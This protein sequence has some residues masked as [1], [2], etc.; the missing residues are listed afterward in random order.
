[1]ASSSIAALRFIRGWLQGRSLH[2]EWGREAAGKEPDLAGVRAMGSVGGPWPPGVSGVRTETRIIENGNPVR[3]RWYG[4]AERNRASRRR[5]LPGWAL[6]HGVAVQGPD[7]PGLVRFATALASAGA[8]VL[9]PEVRAWGRLDLD[10]AAADPVVLETIRHMCA[11]PEVAPGGVV[12]AGFSFGCPQVLR[13]AAKTAGSGRVRGVVG[14][15]GYCELADALRFGL[16]GSYTWAG[17]TRRAR[18]DPYGR[19]VAGANYLHRIPG[20]EGAEEVSE[21]LHTLAV[22]AGAQGV[23][24]WEPH[25]DRLKQE[26]ADTLSPGDRELFRLFAP[27]ADQ[28]PDPN[29]AATLAARLAEAA[30]SV[31]PLLALPRPFDA[32]GMPPVH[33]VH[34]RNDP[35]VPF[36]ESLALQQR[37]LEAGAP[38]VRT[39]VTRLVAHARESGNIAAQPAEAL[40]FARALRAMMAM[41]QSQPVAAKPRWPRSRQR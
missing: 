8:A 13:L 3:A 31:H 26:L 23:L 2:A 21:A 39:T 17:R 29:E 11:D 14:F 7:H 27:P 4:P 36:A 24:A 5:P 9:I 33:L 37:L 16:A 28:E 20:F 34:G 38:S 30:E 32:A 22:V 25:Y 41:A 6:L 10:P 15:G 12:L 35:L 1:M 40:R 19:W 18:P